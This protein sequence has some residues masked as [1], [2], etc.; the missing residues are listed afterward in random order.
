MAA[1]RVRGLHG[2]RSQHG[3]GWPSWWKQIEKLVLGPLVAPSLALPQQGPVWH[4]GFIEGSL[5]IF[6]V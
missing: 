6:L 4:V 1:D 5:F 2:R 3:G